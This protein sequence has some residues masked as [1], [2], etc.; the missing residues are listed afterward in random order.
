MNLDLRYKVLDKKLDGKIKYIIAVVDNAKSLVEKLLPKAKEYIEGL[1]EWYQVDKDAM[2]DYGIYFPEEL[3]IVYSIIVAYI[4]AEETGE[5]FDPEAMEE[6]GYGLPPFALYRNPDAR[7]YCGR[8]GYSEN[9]YSIDEMGVF[10]E[11]SQSS[12][13]YKFYFNLN[14]FLDEFPLATIV[15]AIWWD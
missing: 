2:K 6:D 9:S 13:P 15:W 11:F 8:W 7:S 4:L 14:Y 5:Y 10:S 1:E 12:V 3:D